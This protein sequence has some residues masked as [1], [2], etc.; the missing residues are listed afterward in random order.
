LL[1]VAGVLI[2][3]IRQLADRKALWRAPRVPGGPAREAWGKIYRNR[4][5]RFGLQRGLQDMGA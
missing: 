1:G 3:G 5:Y 4:A 2:L